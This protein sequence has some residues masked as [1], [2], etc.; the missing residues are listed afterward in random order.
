M[1]T[2]I[3][4]SKG[5]GVLSY[6]ELEELKQER[7]TLLSRVE[8]TRRKLA[9]E[10]KL[11]DAAQ[12]LNRLYSTHG[13]RESSESNLDKSPTSPKK[14][15]RSFLG[16]RNSNADTISRT[17]DEFAAST[18]KC[19]ELSNELS[20]LEKRLEE[21]QRK[22]LEHTAG[23]LQMTHRGLKK[24]VRRGELPRSPESMMSTTHR[25]I[26]AFD[27]ISDFDE[28]S[29]YRTNGFEESNPQ[30]PSNMLN[31]KSQTSIAQV[32]ALNDAEQRLKDVNNRLRDMILRADPEQKMEP[33][34]LLSSSEG[35]VKPET[36]IQEHLGYLAV[37]LDTIE[38]HQARTLH[39]ARAS[40][41]D[42]VTKFEDLNVRLH[43]MLEKTSTTG[44][45]PVT[46]PLDLQGKGMQAQFALAMTA[47][48]RLNQRLDLFIEQKE[49]LGRQV[50]QQRD[51]NFKSDA[52][53][54]AQIRDLTDE[55]EEARRRQTI[56]EREEQSLRE[57]VNLLMEQIDSAR[58]EATLIEQKHNVSSNSALQAEKEA[59]R[60][61]E[62]DFL[63]QLKS[64]QDKYTQLQADMARL[65][66]NFDLQMQ[67]HLT[68]V[69]DLTKAKESA[70]KEIQ[71][72]R[73]E[74]K[75]LESEVVRA[76]TDLT[77]VRAELDGAYGTRAQRAADVSMNPAI[78]K[79]IDDLNDSNAALQR[80]IDYL[81]SEQQ[82][83]G[84]SGEELQS[85]VEL[86]QKELKETIEDYEVM[87]R[88]SIEFE[89]ERDQ[90]ESQIDSL[91]ERGEALEAQ[92]SDEKLKWLGMKNGGPGQGGPTESTSTMVL[93]NEFKKMMRDTRA[94]N[95]KG[96]RVGSIGSLSCVDA[97]S[98]ITGRA[99]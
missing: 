2:A 36:Q 95:M 26:P 16:S 79:E 84:A 98:N 33:P 97:N 90:L 74:M 27:G 69:N 10:S 17:D 19:E 93:K 65:Q 35:N 24:N 50:Q 48:D 99:R 72:C 11:R 5:Y 75:E 86:L 32:Q 56:A 47:L 13:R 37:G 46:V 80:Q 91:R 51:L 12:S 43:G 1:E 44:Q 21:V 34:P 40:T 45:A 88:A 41:N 4:D 9:L 81:K 57:Q 8:A 14:H 70:D 67:S 89:K 22:I 64:Q 20:A 60:Q 18:R 94:E 31:E 54:D 3:G 85:K 53:K 38:A 68:M 87:T 83:V 29:F 76:Q 77:V 23:V 66:E 58:Q 63:A 49:I 55:I 28:R 52:Q 7:T 30:G 96:L 73:V 6:E 25:S 39:D 92:L 59:R 82:N 71:R 15:R 62:G 61:A 42:S 78:Q